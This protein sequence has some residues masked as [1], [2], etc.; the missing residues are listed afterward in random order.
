MNTTALPRQA[1]SS[2]M[3]STSPEER[4]PAWVQPLS[5]N[6]RL[7]ES[8]IPTVFVVTFLV[9]MTL[10]LSHLNTV[11]RVNEIEAMG[12]DIAHAGERLNRHLEADRRFL[13]S[14]AEQIPAGL[15]D[16]DLFEQQ[17]R[18][19]TQ[20]HSELTNIGWV[21]GI[22][23]IRSTADPEVIEHMVD[24]ALLQPGARTAFGDARGTGNTAYTVKLHAIEGKSTLGIYVPMF[25]KDEFLGAVAGVYSLQTL[26]RE[27]LP[28]GLSARY[29]VSVVCPKVG[30]L[31]SLSQSSLIDHTL[32]RRI[33]IDGTSLKLELARYRAKRPLH[34]VMLWVIA[35]SFA[36][37]MA[38]SMSLLA[39]DISKRH[40]LHRE[41]EVL[42]AQLGQKNAE[43]E[44]YAYT[45][46]HDL[47][48]PLFAIQGFTELLRHDMDSRDR[49]S[50][51]EDMTEI[52]RATQSMTTLLNNLLDL[53]RYGM[54]A[55]NSQTLSL[56]ELIHEVLGVSSKEIRIKTAIENDLP[57]IVGD[58][59][60]LL[61]VLQNLVD[62][63]L[64]FGESAQCNT[65][66]IGAEMG[67][68]A[69]VC[70]VRDAGVGIPREHH[71]RVFNLFERLHTHKPG[72]G[73]GLAIVKR[74][75][76]AHGG[77]V[78][79]ESEGHNCGTTMLF[80]L[81]VAAVKSARRD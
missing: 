7:F 76:E 44:R 39:R 25:G 26:L 67:D 3:T 23:V 9:I 10:L 4:G 57:P 79:I 29:K 53:S 34:I 21:E 2:A 75:V 16:Y 65:I 40:R 69:V 62:N 80:S 38:W 52:E 5:F 18:H 35:A 48:A 66:T 8:V 31:A 73:V 61:I 50:I 77:K 41:H 56:E 30:E 58:R 47:K 72:T 59:G 22:R 32:T 63:A 15:V 51:E 46:S 68:C 14:L 19:Y 78:W 12:Q 42:I 6:R 45:I 20:E 1:V 37:G 43:L 74:I 33:A 54:V 71:E 81:P 13:E 24:E 11:Q 17:A 70:Y 28:R 49:E 27:V 64:K 60:R 36:I 55:N